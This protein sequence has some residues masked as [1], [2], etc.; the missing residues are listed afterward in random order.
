MRPQSGI[1]HLN[2]IQ[3]LSL[4]EFW[5]PIDQDQ[6]L[7]TKS[8]GRQNGLVLNLRLCDITALQASKS[9]II[10]KIKIHH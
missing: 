7:T 4:G 1:S 3:D 9:D 6:V 5:R 8:R 10:I 2:T